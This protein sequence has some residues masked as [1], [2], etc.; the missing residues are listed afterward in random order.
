MESKHG[1]IRFL[2]PL[3]PRNNHLQFQSFSTQNSAAELG[4]AL[5]VK[6]QAE[7]AIR[8]QRQNCLQEDAGHYRME[9]IHICNDW[10][11]L[12][13][14]SNLQQVVSKQAVNI[15]RPAKP[16][17]GEIFIAN[18]SHF[19]QKLHKHGQQDSLLVAV[20]GQFACQ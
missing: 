6:G 16:E 13:E 15:E 11:G 9:D 18:I 4:A 8:L 20:R 17:T 1:L 2:V 12:S 10:S 14:S 5:M 7:M 19:D 3:K